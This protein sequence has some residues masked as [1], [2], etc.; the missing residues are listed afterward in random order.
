MSDLSALLNNNNNNKSTEFDDLSSDFLSDTIEYKFYTISKFINV[1]AITVITILGLLGNLLS[2]HVFCSKQYKRIPLKIYLL[3]LSI[4]D[5]VVLIT[6]YTDFTFR[7]W[8]NLHGVFDSNINFVDKSWIFCKLVSYLRNVFRTSSAYIMLLMTWER[9]I[10]LYFPMKK[11]KLCS[12]RINK[13]LIRILIIISLTLNSPIL[14]LADIVK[15]PNSDYNMCEIKETFKTVYFYLNVSF[16]MFTILIPIILVG[17]F[18]FIL[19][20]KIT[21]YVSLARF[22]C[23]FERGNLNYEK[24]QK[25]DKIG[26]IV[27]ASAT[28]PKVYH[29]CHK[30]HVSNS[31]NKPNYSLRTTYMLIILSKWFIILHVPY[32]IC[33]LLINIDEFN[34]KVSNSTS[35]DFTFTSYTLNVEHHLKSETRKCILRA[36]HNISEVIYIANYAINFLLYS[37]NG[38]LFRKR[39]KD[40]LIYRFAGCFKLF[41]K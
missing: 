9:F 5:I 36:F 28:S 20:Y 11:T 33:W 8:I 39:Y 15:D 34:N 2:I 6:H 38:K 16:V 12:F 40:L 7:A 18:T 13:I 26:V 1:Y 25:I 19:L 23:T 29:E 27:K 32:F 41:R 21:E 4:S 30:K 22:C 14:Y 37:I 3:S 31:Q 10:A 17:I 35:Y 24:M